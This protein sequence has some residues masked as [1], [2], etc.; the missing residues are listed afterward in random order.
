VGGF[1][2]PEIKIMSIRSYNELIGNRPHIVLTDSGFTRVHPPVI[3]HLGDG[4]EELQTLI[5]QSVS[6]I[7]N[8]GHVSSYPVDLFSWS[9][10]NGRSHYA[11]SITLKK[12]RFHTTYEVAEV[13]AHGK[14]L[15]PTFRSI[16]RGDASFSLDWKVPDSIKLSL[17]FYIDTVGVDTTRYTANDCYLFARKIVMGNP[18]GETYILPT[19]NV[20]DQGRVC[21]GESFMSGLTLLECADSNLNTFYSTP[22]NADLLD[23]RAEKSKKMF[24]FNH[25]T[26][27]QLDSLDE[28]DNLILFNNTNLN[29]I[30]I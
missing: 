21:F 4:Q 18:E 9:S 7:G 23:N 24:R 5:E 26:N 25:E 13:E 29:K 1:F 8:V 12:L 14:W 30:L 19:G 11:A 6:K 10:S 3:E 22:W 28:S 27:E 17:V 15:H 2:C 20:Y 16:D